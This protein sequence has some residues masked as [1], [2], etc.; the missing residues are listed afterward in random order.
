MKR[1]FGIAFA[2]FT[3]C[4]IVLVSIEV[5]CFGPTGSDASSRPYCALG[6]YYMLER[7]DYVAAMEWYT[8]AANHRHTNYAEHAKAL[9]NLAALCYRNG[10]LGRA[11]VYINQ[12]INM[13]P[14]VKH[15]YLTKQSVERAL[16]RRADAIRS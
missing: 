8:L 14:R 10:E 11:L 12:A 13:A 6:D 4:V 15:F 5:E 7:K 3:A 16:R 2:T 1:Y 9:N